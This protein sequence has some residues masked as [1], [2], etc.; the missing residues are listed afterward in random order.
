MRKV[1]D[2]A[3][4]VEKIAH[5]QPTEKEPYQHKEPSPLEFPDWPEEDINEIK[6]DVNIRKKV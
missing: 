6:E 3:T 5:P 1:F 4:E 2:M